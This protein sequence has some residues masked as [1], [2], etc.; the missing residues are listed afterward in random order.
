MLCFLPWSED[1]KN[2]SII[3][4]EMEVDQHRGLNCSELQVKLAA[5]ATAINSSWRAEDETCKLNVKQQV[6][7]S[8]T[9]VKLRGDWVT[10]NWC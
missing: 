8:K 7:V 2:S 9:S 3:K 4:V 5:A 10:G 1:D 6:K